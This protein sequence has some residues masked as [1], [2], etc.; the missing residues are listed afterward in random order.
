M[1]TVVAQPFPSDPLIKEAANLGQFIRA[2]RT[3][4]G[5]TL[6][7]AALSLGIAKQTLQDLERGKPT[8]SFGLVLRVAQGLGVA[9]FAQ[10]AATRDYAR[11][12]LQGTP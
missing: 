12:C 9:V 10:P 3:Q 8:V 6:A 5:L 7:D 11:Q 4:S 2:A 1:R